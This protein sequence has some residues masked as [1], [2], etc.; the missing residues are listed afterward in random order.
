MALAQRAGGLMPSSKIE[1][2]VSD[3]TRQAT[4]GAAPNFAA[5]ARAL[6]AG[7]LVDDR[8]FDR[9]FPASMRRASR[10]HWTPVEVAMRAANLLASRPDS[11]ILDVG[12]GIGK[13][14]IVAAAAV[15]KVRVRG[16]EHRPHLVEI[17][18]G[19][20]QKLGVDVDFA[21]G[22]LDLVDPTSIDGLYLFN[23]FAENLSSPEDR[24][25]ESIELGEQRFWRDIETTKRFLRVARTGTRVVTYCG[26][27]GV[28]PS[29]YE[30]VLRESRAG[31][32]EL[33]MKSDRP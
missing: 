32:I 33:W 1:S 16:V 27:G 31:T 18:R 22:T 9:V 19:A 4:E 13:F 29:E 15:P 25:D 24:L 14:C 2:W 26:W 3:T 21:H 23:P 28:M 30:L 6:R 7:R 8:V 5:S 12:S 11:T 20:A 10:T 17:A